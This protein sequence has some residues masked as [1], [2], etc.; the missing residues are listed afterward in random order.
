MA[1]TGFVLVNNGHYTVTNGCAKKI[2]GCNSGVVLEDTEVI[3]H[4]NTNF[5]Q[6]TASLIIR[7]KNRAKD[8][9]FLN[10]IGF[11][12]KIQYSPTFIT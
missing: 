4:L 3:T 10:P 1:A 6:I 5:N 9:F 12:G 2:G 8:T 11:P 7:K